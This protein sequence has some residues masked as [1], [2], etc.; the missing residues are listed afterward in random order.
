MNNIEKRKLTLLIALLSAFP[1][2]TTDM[3]LPAIPLLQKLWEEPLATMNLTLV[4]FFLGYCISLL[5]Y[6]P[7]SDKY[8]RRPLLLAGIGIYIVSSLLA[9]FVDNAISLII[10]RIFQGLG[11]ASGSALGLAMTKDLFD[12]EERKKIL[13]TIAVVTPLAPMLAPIFG[14]WIM[15]YLSW[16][17]IFVAQAFIGCI[18][19]FGV[20]RMD[21]SLNEFSNSKFRHM[22]KIYLQ[23]FQNKR[24]I[25]LV[26]LFTFS[27]LVHYSFIG[28]AADIYINRFGFSEQI[29]GYFFALNALCIMAG[30]FTCGR[31]KNTL[32]TNTLLTFSFIG[33]FTS[34]I[35]MVLEIFSGPWGLALPMM[36]ASFCFGLSRPTSNHLVLEQVSSHVGSASSLMV[37]FNFVIGAFAMWFIAHDWSDKIVTIGQLG[38]LSIGVV[39]SVWLMINKTFFTNMNNKT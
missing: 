39:L 16:S 21:E 1:P 22:G 13:A 36:L 5:I 6:G 19:W 18:A 25:I 38:I 10:L 24:Y 2:L 32:N 35:T 9:C 8:G 4:A 17:W 23:L 14:G 12:G 30:A 15:A 26:M 20:F 27:A 34:S 29:F 28:S 37:F 31:L 11:A 33:I 3:Y 7:L